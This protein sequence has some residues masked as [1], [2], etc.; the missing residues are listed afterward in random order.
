LVNPTFIPVVGKPHLY[1]SVWYTPPLFQWL[2]NHT[3]IP[4]VGKPHLYASG[5]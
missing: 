4:V 2:V 3:F 5:W 1:S